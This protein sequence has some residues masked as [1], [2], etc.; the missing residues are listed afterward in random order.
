M[1]FS[2]SIHLAFPGS[3]ESELEAVCELHEGCR[4]WLLNPFLTVGS[5][6]VLNLNRCWYT[7]GIPV[8]SQNCGIMEWLELVSARRHVGT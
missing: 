8:E 7:G 2:S 4:N 3:L 1:I 5:I 6:Y